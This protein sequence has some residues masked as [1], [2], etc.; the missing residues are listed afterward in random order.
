MRPETAQKFEKEIGVA[1]REAGVSY[2]QAKSWEVFSM[3][4]EASTS[5]LERTVADLVS[6]VDKLEGKV[7]DLEDR[8]EALEKRV[9]V[10][11]QAK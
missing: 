4:A 10:K 9:G 8:V 5:D 2:V 1:L 3:I 11:R 6:R 7:A